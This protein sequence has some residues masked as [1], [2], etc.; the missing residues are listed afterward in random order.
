[1]RGVLFSFTANSYGVVAIQLLDGVAAG[2]FGVIAIVIASD[3]M[4]GTGRFNLAQGLVALGIGVGAALSNLISGFIIQWYGYP[5]GFLS[6]A[7]VAMAAFAFFAL[8][9]PETQGG[10]Q[11]RVAPAAALAVGA[12]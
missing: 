8:F 6:L 2:V 7:A 1:V 4:R 12:Q 9:M 3:L 5:A 11:C 10:V